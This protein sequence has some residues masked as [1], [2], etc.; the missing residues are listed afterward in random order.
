MVFVPQAQLPDEVNTLS[1]SIQPVN[2]VVRTSVEP[3]TIARIVQEQIGQVTGLPVS[4]VQSMESI[5]AQSTSRQRFN[6][7]LMTAF[8]GVALLLA[9]IGIYGLMAYSVAQRRR[10]VAIRLTLGAQ[11]SDVRWMV[12]FQGMRLAIIGV[13][14][15]LGAAFALARFVGTMVY[16]VGVHDP[17]V[18]TAVPV[19]LALAALVAVLVPAVRASRVDPVVA[20]TSE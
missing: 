10:E 7:W 20:L 5:V 14:I 13:V 1:L 16:D 11:A 9:A 3:M 19:V 18:F 15:G 17:F 6:L 2:W 8:S 12:V 4:E